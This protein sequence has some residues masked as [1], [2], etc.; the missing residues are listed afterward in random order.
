MAYYIRSEVSKI[1][2]KVFRFLKT[3]DNLDQIDTVNDLWTNIY[4]ITQET[5]IGPVEGISAK[6]TL[7]AFLC[8][9]L[10]AVE[11]E[12]ARVENMYIF[13]F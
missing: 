4:S 12:Q 6:N 11:L 9:D 5:L 7:N 10:T 13:S 3:G 2:V 8:P 1:R